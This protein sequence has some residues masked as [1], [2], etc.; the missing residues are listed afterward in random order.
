MSIED[1]FITV[2]AILELRTQ[3]IGVDAF[4]LTL[5]KAERQMRKLFTHLVFQSSGFSLAD[6]PGLREKLAANRRVYFE[7]FIRGWDTLY[8]RS[9]RELI[10]APYDRLLGR[11]IEAIDHR[12]KIFHG[13]LT[14]K[15]LST[16]DLLMYVK[17][18]RSWCDTLASGTQREVSYDGFARNSFRKSIDESLAGRLRVQMMTLDDYERFIREHMERPNNALQRMSLT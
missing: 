11:L 7:G 2:D 18:I 9:V 12:N 3:T 5:I 1:E 8:P 6:I 10:G 13:Q 17:D 15:Y 4:A 14:T 16:D